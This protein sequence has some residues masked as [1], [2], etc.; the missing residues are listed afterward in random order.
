MEKVILPDGSTY[1]YRLVTLFP[2]VKRIDKEVAAE[3]LSLLK[4]VFD[5]NHIVFQLAFGSLLGAVREHDFISHDED[6][7][8]ALLDDYRVA[9]LR[10]LPTLRK[11]GFELCRFDRR[12]LYSLM[13]KG[14]YIDLYFFRPYN[15]ILSICS[16]WVIK[17]SH[18]T[19]SMLYPFK[20]EMYNIPAEYE[21]YLVGNYGQ[22][23]MQ[24]V[25]WNNYNP[26]MWK[27]LFFSLK[28]KI[29]MSLPEKM[30]TPLAS[31]AAAALTQRSIKKL[32][33]E[34]I[35]EKSSVS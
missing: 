13:R 14:E 30:F 8:L 10:L 32:L 28:E 25:V 35:I 24:P 33:D 6:I 22:N 31:K 9:F 12:D 7:D 11:E 15:E 34:G 3:N 5:E 23:W 2:G 29:K 27:K 26:P 20:D 21:S 4:K 17:T 1:R 18:L 16:G 19:N